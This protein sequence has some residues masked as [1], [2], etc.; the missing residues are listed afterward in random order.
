MSANLQK[1]KPGLALA[2]LLPFAIWMIASVV[3]I[4]F[5]V[6]GFQRA[7]D[8]SDDFARIPAAQDQTVDLTEAGDYRI[9]IDT[10]SS[11]DRFSPSATATITGPDGQDVPANTYIGS[12]EY[13]D[14]EAVLT[15]DAPQAG[16]Y[17]FNVQEIGFE[18]DPTGVE[19]AIGKGNPFAE[20]GTGFLFMF[21]IGGV[22]FVIA[23]IVMIIML[24]KRGRSKKRIV[25]AGLQG[26]GG[27]GGGYPPP[28]GYQ[29]PGGY[30][31]PGGY[32]QPGSSW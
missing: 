8:V 12:L 32:Q 21:L 2:L 23:L 1:P 29:Q 18:P 28:G 15:F 27:Y 4:V 6:M 17:T 20:V 31:P 19:F 13:N 22:G 7:E 30:P 10:S 3:A 16:E 11:T 14:L 25:Q 24:V 26:G 9:W 5:L